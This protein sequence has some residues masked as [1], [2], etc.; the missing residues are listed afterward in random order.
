MNRFALHVSKLL[1]PRSHIRISRPD[2]L[3]HDLRAVEFSARITRQWLALEDAFDVSTLAGA[4]F[5][6][7][8]IHVQPLR[9]G[10]PAHRRTAARGPL[11]AQEESLATPRT[12]KMKAMASSIQWPRRKAKPQRT[13][14]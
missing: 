3:R 6:A 7:H 8:W 12:S 2:L 11:A 14:N 1:P 13:T 4:G 10:R 5:D 9:A